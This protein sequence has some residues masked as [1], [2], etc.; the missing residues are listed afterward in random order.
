MS[1]SL[2]SPCLHCAGR[3]PGVQCS[4]HDRSRCYKFL[5]YIQKLNRIKASRVLLGELK[6]LI[7]QV[8]G[9]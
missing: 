1:T 3:L 9:K 8:G 6:N 4:P 2:F 5:D 7:C